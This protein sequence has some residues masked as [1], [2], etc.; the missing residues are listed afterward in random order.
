VRSLL[1]L[2]NARSGSD[3]DAVIG[4]VVDVLQSAGAD[5]EVAATDSPDDI[6]AALARADGRT[7][8]VAGG[9]G[10]LHAVVTSLHHRGT[11]SNATLGLVPLGTGNDFARGV[12]LPS[13]P[14]E[15][16]RVV[17]TGSPTALDLLVDGDGG[18]VVNA[19]HVGLGADAGRAAQRWKPRLGRAGYVAGALTAGFRAT[20]Q[21]LRVEVDDEVVTTG[22]RRVLQVAVG[23]APFVGGGTELVPAAEPTDGRVDVVVSFA[24]SPL[25]RAWYAVLLRLGRHT[26]D[27]DVDSRRGRS[28]RISGEPFWCNADGELS[29][30][31]RERSWTVMPGAYR[32]VVPSRG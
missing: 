26:A 13:D 14:T 7:V 28:V 10:S 5:V 18:V 19:V 2:R 32:L 23:N 27:D 22:R 25:A 11:L 15:A 21:R 30:P 16:A 17:A 31:H 1:L 9:D 6:D 12:G 24:V 8:V 29:G 3:D 4:D 20:G